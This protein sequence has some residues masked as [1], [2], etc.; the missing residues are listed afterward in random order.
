MNKKMNYSP[1]SKLKNPIFLIIFIF[2]S[3]YTISLIFPLVWGIM[4]SFKERVDFLSNSIFALPDFSYW[5]LNK[6]IEEYYGYDN[7]F[8][9]YTKIL[10]DSEIKTSSAYYKGFYKRTLIRNTAT[11]DIADYISNSILYAVVASII[12]TFSPMTVAYLCSKYKCKFASVVHVFVIFVITTPIVGG[13][14]GT[15]NLARQLGLFDNWAGTFIRSIGFANTY[16][17]IFFSFFEGASNTFA[18]AAEIDG[19]S[20]F[21]VMV[22]IYFPLA[23]AMFSTVLLL[24]FVAAW[25]DYNTSLMFLPTHLTLAY[26]IYYFTSTGASENDSAPFRIAAAMLLAIPVL[27]IFVIFKNKLMGNLSLGGLK[28]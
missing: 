7:P 27:V 2:L 22:T 3:L 23:K 26:A 1:L 12:R 11:L 6:G 24:T 8:G 21:R 20:Q 17:L 28:E 18:E 14:T 15:L 19:A 5:D 10:M 4:T 16:F 25:N 9:N 13:V